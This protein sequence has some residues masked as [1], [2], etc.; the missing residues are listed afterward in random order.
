MVKLPI[1]IRLFE[2]TLPV[3]SSS[4]V[5]LATFSANSVLPLAV[6]PV[7]LSNPPSGLITAPTVVPAVFE[8][9]LLV[10]FTLE[11]SI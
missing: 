10:G 4:S 9:E 6:K 7:V 1:V 8:T 5:I 3:W 11:A 2:K